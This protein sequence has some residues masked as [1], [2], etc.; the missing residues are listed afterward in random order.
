MHI[1]AEVKN[2]GQDQGLATNL[3]DEFCQEQVKFVS[4]QD[5]SWQDLCSIERYQ[6]LANTTK[7]GR[8]IKSILLKS[9]Q[10]P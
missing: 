4:C 10:E 8:M 7:E 5:F 9:F 2:L 6:I 3:S 1:Q